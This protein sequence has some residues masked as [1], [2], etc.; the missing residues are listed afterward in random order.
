MGCGELCPHVEADEVGE[1]LFMN[2]VR[3]FIFGAIIGLFVFVGLMFSVIY[4][5]A[6]GLTFTCNR[7]RPK[8]DLTPIPTLIPVRLSAATQTVQPTPTPLMELLGTPTEALP[9][10]TPEAETHPLPGSQPDI[11][12]PSNPGGPGPAIDLTGN[13][14]SGQQI[15]VANCQLCHGEEGK[16]GYSNPGSTDETV[17]P[18]NPI[19]ETLVDSDLKTYAL[20]IDLFIEHGSVPEGPMPVRNMPAWGDRGALDPQQI[21]DVIAYIISLNK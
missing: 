16:G 8:L 5:S 2:D 19:D 20:N 11:A 15:Y 17:P 1:E 6:C 14:E 13:V 12:R 21:A 9:L 4:I 10:L 7:S 3:K 18:L